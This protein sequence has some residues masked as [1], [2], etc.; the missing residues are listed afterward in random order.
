MLELV[1][2][3]AVY[4]G[5]A[6][7]SLRVALVERNVT[8]VWPPTGIALAVFL[9][10]GP[11][12]WPAIAVAAFVVNAPISPSPAVAL[13]IAAGN[14]LAP[15]LALFLLRG[16]GFRL[17]IDRLRDAMAIVFLGALVGMLVSATMGTTALVTSG[18]V[19]GSE[20][21][22]TW[23]VWWTGDAM[24]VLVVAPFLLSLRRPEPSTRISWPR[25]IEA[26]VLFLSLAAVSYTVFQSRVEIQYLVFPFL[27]WAAWRFQLRG[28]APAALIASGTAVWAAVH[29]TGPFEQATLFQ[30]MVALQVFNV[31]IAFTSFV[32]A[33]VVTERRRGREALTRA[34]RDLEERVRQR[35]SEL[36]AANERLSREVQERERAE[37]ELGTTGD[38]LA[39]A[40]RIAHI[41]SWEWDMRTDSVTWSEE[42]FHIF[43]LRTDEFGGSYRAFL[44]L[45]HGDDRE[46]ADQ[47]VRAAVKDGEDF[48]FDH[49]IVRPDGVERILHARGQVIMDGAGS[50]VRMVGTAQD[51]TAE[52]RGEDALRRFIANAS[53]ELRTPLT[54]MSGLARVLA[55]KRGELTPEV[56]D[57]LV[58][59]LGQQGDRTARL[60]ED[61]LDL[62]RAEQGQATARAEPVELAEAARRVL[63]TTSPPDGTSVDVGVPEDLVVLAEP[64]SLERVLINLLTNAFNYGGPRVRID[65]TGDDGTSR[66][67]VADD[68]P[69]VHPETI[70]DLFEPFTR[71]PVPQGTGS[72]LGLAIARSLVESFGG[73]IHYEPGAPRGARFVMSLPLAG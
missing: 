26:I 70:P 14:T 48:E 65:A 41:G 13:P 8:P 51:V 30:N 68:G 59:T 45:V 1:A 23:A 11:R 31:A 12:M 18:A 7:L 71:G 56:F 63:R 10:L 61:L 29:G 28:A 54:A 66:I 6:E 67:V 36:S 4:V 32:L 34:A 46:R 72:G 58:T 64:A 37:A 33:A 69:G 40:Q 21:G 55:D 27:G 19:P 9:I 3:A 17:Q 62:S 73:E 39:Q 22:A 42:L 24:G 20:Y 53:H 5:A 60:I 49:R 15:L 47:I 35:T 2:V 44:D 38:L 52:R 25:A 57:E 16:V 43:G 50:S